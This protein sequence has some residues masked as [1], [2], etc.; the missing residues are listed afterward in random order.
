MIEG[1]RELSAIIQEL[2]DNDIKRLRPGIDYRISL[3]GKA[4]DRAGCSD[5]NDAAGLPLFTF[6][7]ENIFKKET[8]LAFISL[9]DNYESDTGEPEIVTPEEELENHKFLDSVLKTPTMKIAHRYLVEKHLSPEDITDLKQQLY[10]IWFELYARRGSSKPDSSGFEHV[11]V[12]ETRGG[13][14][15]IG[16]HNWIQLYL[17]EKLGHIDYKGYSVDANSPQPD[18]NKHILALQFCWKNGIKPKGSIFI[19]V[20]PEFEFA[21]YTLCFLTSPN[22]RVKVSFNIYEVEIVCHHY[23]QKHIGTTYPVLVKYLNVSPK[24]GVD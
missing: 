14:T 6:V 19:G 1:D 11:F 17:Q 4:G 15:V 9:L 8:F 13:H 22:E 3:Q 18:D 7:D 10:R 24:K 20:S 2:W 16:F 12:G 23:N 21:L 5:G